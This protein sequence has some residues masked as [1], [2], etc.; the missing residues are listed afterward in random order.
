MESSLL[1]MRDQKLAGSFEP[2]N[3]QPMPTIARG[4]IGCETE[5]TTKETS[6]GRPAGWGQHV[7]SIERRTHGVSRGNRT[8]E[9]ASLASKIAF[10]RKR[11][12]TRKGKPRATRSNEVTPTAASFSFE[13]VG[14]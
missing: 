14:L 4:V 6:P 3:R 13:Q 10:A 7:T 5:S 11:T 8:G 2:G 12:R 1:T 9:R